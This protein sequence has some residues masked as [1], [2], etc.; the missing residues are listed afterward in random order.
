MREQ[1]IQYVE[2]LFAGARDC[3]D[4]KQEILQN[5]L[6]RYDDLIAEGKVPEAAYRL[7]ITGIG[8]IN[9]ILGSKPQAAPISHVPV[10]QQTEDNDTPTKKLL[11][12]IAIGLYILCPL[13]LFV[14]SDLGMDTLGLCGLL[15]IVAVATVLIILGGKKSPKQSAEKFGFEA[16]EVSP[17]SELGKSISGLIWTIGLAL[18]FLISFTTGA[19]YVTWVIFPILGA[20]D[21]LLNTLIVKNEAGYEVNISSGNKLHKSVGS[22]IWAIGLAVYFIVSFATHAWYITW[23]LFPIIGA[24]QGLVRAIMDLKEAV[25]NEA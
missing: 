24:V 9:E 8:D 23:V 19:W 12:A 20:V 18:Y 6:D 11:R 4:I 10:Q 14:L 15:G 16:E 5:T 7:A 13:P 17:K 22:M 3:E 21:K 1:L 25:E 2:L